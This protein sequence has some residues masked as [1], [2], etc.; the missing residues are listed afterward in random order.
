MRHLIRQR[1]R[2][3]TLVYE[4]IEESTPK[5]PLGPSYGFFCGGGSG[6]EGIS[7]EKKSQ[8][9]DSTCGYNSVDF[10]IRGKPR[11]KENIYKWV[12]V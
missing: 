10:I 9:E 12:S 5:R 1:M 4:S 8:I 7:T 11:V 6:I 3:Q 2:L